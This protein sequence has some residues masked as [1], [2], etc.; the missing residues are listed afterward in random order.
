[1]AEGRVRQEAGR[2]VVDAPAPDGALTNPVA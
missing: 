2:I 1:V